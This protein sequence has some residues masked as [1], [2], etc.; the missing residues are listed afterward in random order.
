MNPD[1]SGD[2][3]V[4]TSVNA[5]HVNTVAANFRYVMNCF[6]DCLAL[7]KFDIVI[8]WWY[9][10][11]D[12]RILLLLLLIYPHRSVA[13]I[14]LIDVDPEN[15]FIRP[16][17]AVKYLLLDRRDVRAFRHQSVVRTGSSVDDVPRRPSATSTRPSERIFTAA[18]T[19][20]GHSPPQHPTIPLAV[21]TFYTGRRHMVSDF[22]SK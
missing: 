12:H 7:L 2:N 1:R 9:G 17:A 22:Y 13:I 6:V 4:H 3:I 20:R 10:A 18:I 14:H 19:I 15:N 21:I 16:C 5:K 11:T 8:C